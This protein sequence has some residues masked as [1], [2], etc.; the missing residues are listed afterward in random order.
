[1]R[2][3]RA[4]SAVTES[5]LR[6]SLPTRLNA[7]NSIHHKLSAPDAPGLKTSGSGS[8]ILPTSMSD[9]M[10]LVREQEMKLRASSGRVAD[11]NTSLTS[12]IE[13]S[14]GPGESTNRLN[15]SLPGEDG[16]LSRMFEP[17]GVRDV[18]QRYDPEGRRNVGG[19]LVRN[20][21]SSQSSLKDMA[22]L[23]EMVKAQAESLRASGEQV[24]QKARSRSSL[25]QSIG[26][27]STGSRE[28]SPH[29]S[30]V[31]ADEPL[32][33]RSIERPTQLRDSGA[34]FDLNNNI[35]ESV[36]SSLQSG[37]LAPPR[38]S[39]SP[40]KMRR[41]LR[42]GSSNIPPPLTLPIDTDVISPETPQTAKTVRPGSYIDQLQSAKHASSAVEAWVEDTKTMNAD[43][44]DVNVAAS[45]E[46]FSGL[47]V[48]TDTYP[49]PDQPEGC[50]R[51]PEIL[52]APSPKL[53]EPPQSLVD[54]VMTTSQRTVTGKTPTTPTSSRPTTTVPR[55]GIAPAA[56]G[57]GSRGGVAS[58]ALRG[59]SA[60]RPPITQRSRPPT[61]S[62]IPVP[63]LAS[64]V[65]PSQIRPPTRIRPPTSVP[66]N[67]SMRG[68]RGPGVSGSSRSTSRSGFN[69][70]PPPEY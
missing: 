60:I 39:T 67:R 26:A 42:G 38:R 6:D 25:N 29:I 1:M 65:A 4:P 3:T 54:N 11:V 10:A 68:T 64:R 46:S 45:G 61:G 19:E 35:R 49:L 41:P 63:T 37:D 8:N 40:V 56:V 31:A 27:S 47:R 69:N 32:H 48:S 16:G 57:G 14:G 51:P 17:R 33:H 58:R 55:R 2:S 70:P 24:M 12:S 62:G 23:T 36:N 43:N 7:S 50:P 44:L 66:R 13:G 22:S 52:R 5:Q 21:S 9:A 18:P 34:T 59:G 15:K 28:A 20:K 30:Q 53:V